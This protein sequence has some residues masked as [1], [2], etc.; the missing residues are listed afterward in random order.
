MKSATFRNLFLFLSLSVL[1]ASA[2]AGEIH[3]VSSVKVGTPQPLAPTAP[4]VAVGVDTASGK[5]YTASLELK[6]GP[7]LPPSLTGSIGA[8]ALWEP[9]AIFKVEWISTIPGEQYPD[10]LGGLWYVQQDVIARWN[11]VSAP[12]GSGAITISGGSIPWGGNNFNVNKAYVTG[13]SGGLYQPATATYVDFAYGEFKFADEGGHWI[14]TAEIPISFTA[15]ILG[16]L[17]GGAMTTG[18]SS[19]NQTAITL[20]GCGTYPVI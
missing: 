20:T 8:N 2:C 15:G 11:Y 1:A 12:F 5:T 17:T 18:P 16:T 9:V 4:F 7:G 6:K 13:Q 19:Y 14:G 10:T 3:F